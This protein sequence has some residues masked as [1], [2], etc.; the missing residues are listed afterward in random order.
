MGPA[1]LV[2]S[3]GLPGVCCCGDSQDPGVGLCDSTVG[4][5]T[6]AFWGD[7]FGEKCRGGSLGAKKSLRVMQ[8]QSSGG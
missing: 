1:V 2:T 8:S 4:F 3:P 7:Q 6:Q 5:T